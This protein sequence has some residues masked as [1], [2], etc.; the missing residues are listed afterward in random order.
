MDLLLIILRNIKRHWFRSVLTVL[1]VCVAILAYCMIHTMIDAW[2]AGVKSSA[3]NRLIVRNSVSLVFYLPISY[4]EKIR[5]VPGVAKV[6]RGNW[7]GAVYRDENYR[8]EQFA[9]DQ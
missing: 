9:I 2:F 1:G 3:K 8:F 7:F 6:G 4:Q 5:Q